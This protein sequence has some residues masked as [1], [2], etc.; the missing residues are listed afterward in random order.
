MDALRTNGELP[1]ENF[2]S[3]NDFSASKFPGGIPFSEMDVDKPFRHAACHQ[4]DFDEL[5][6]RE[7]WKTFLISSVR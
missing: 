2:E 5:L 3:N 1:A 4:S 7:S 6:F